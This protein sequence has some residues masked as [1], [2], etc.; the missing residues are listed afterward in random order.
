MIDWDLSDLD[1]AAPFF[2]AN[3]LLGDPERLRQRMERDGYLFFRSL[4]PV[5]PLQ[6]LREQLTAILARRG[7]IQGGEQRLN[8]RVASLPHREGDEEYIATLR[9]TVRLESLHSLPHRSELMQLMQDLL[10]PGAFPHPLSITRL[11]YPRA[12]ELSTPPH[13]DYPN[14]Q[15]TE[16]L[17]AAWI[18]LADCYREQGSLAILEG[19]HRYGLLPLQ[20]HLGPGNRKA[21]TDERLAECRWV[22][23]DFKLGDVLL[24][25]SLTLHRALDNSSEENLRLSVDYRYQPAGAELTPSCLKPHFDCLPWSEIYRGWHSDELQYY[26]RSCDYQEVPWREALHALPEGHLDEALRDEILYEKA[27]LER[28]GK[29]PE[30]PR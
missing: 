5:E 25:P 29:S 7:W 6:A 16:Q 10:G 3:A 15:G 26:W 23:S 8:A 9:E 27:I 18:P 21:V 1:S 19:S 20:F 13:Q 30:Q 24:F 28:Y 12:P 17:T 4:L 11:V 2:E 14:N 22:A